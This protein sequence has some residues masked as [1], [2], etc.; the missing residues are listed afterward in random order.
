MMLT[1]SSIDRKFDT[2][3]CT[4]P[5]LARLVPAFSKVANT[6][7]EVPDVSDIPL[8]SELLR[9]VVFTLPLLRLPMRSITAQFSVKAAAEG[10]ISDVWANDAKYPILDDLKSASVF[11]WHG[12]CYADQRRNVGRQCIAAVETELEQELKSSERML[13]IYRVHCG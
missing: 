9:D 11:S 8:T 7:E 5:E 6:F 10:R 3:Q 4:P 2:S 13:T 12:F 1:C